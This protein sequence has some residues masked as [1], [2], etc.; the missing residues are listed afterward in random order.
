MRFGNPVDGLIGPPG[1]PDPDSG[2]V[3]TQG[4]GDT[5]TPYGPHDGLDVGAS[6]D[7]SGAP[8]LAMAAGEVYQ[9]FYD[10]AS[11]G[12]GIVRV[13]H[14]DGWTSGHAHLKAIAVGVGDQVGTG[15]K[16]GEL[17]STGWVSGPHLH[18]DI[19]RHGERLDPWPYANQPPEAEEGTFWV[20]T[21]GGAEYEHVSGR[22]TTLA[23][24]RF[25]ADTST[26]AAILEE[27]AAG[28][29]MTPHAKVKGGTANGSDRWF[30]AWAY[31][32]GR[33]RLGAFH[34]STLEA[35]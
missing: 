14:G 32:D 6:P 10:S 31:V 29:S 26:S 18:Y 22:Y 35:A 25:R 20:H 23:G 24:A 30:L 2:Y 13:D 7:P 33:Y 21:Y 15:D 16:L 28:Q 17:D 1:A 12:A 4:F 5:A 19:S 34:T 8:V 3:I 9:A 11:G 27:F